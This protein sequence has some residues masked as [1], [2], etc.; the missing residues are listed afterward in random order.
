MPLGLVHRTGIDTRAVGKPRP[1]NPGNR[2]DTGRPD[3]RNRSEPGLLALKPGC[4]KITPVVRSGGFDIAGR[5]ASARSR[6]SDT[7]EIRVREPA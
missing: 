5:R 4:T 6:A 3:D 7:P 1:G 2:P